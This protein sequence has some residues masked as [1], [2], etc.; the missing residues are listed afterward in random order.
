MKIQVSKAMAKELNKAIGFCDIS[1]IEMRPETYSWNVSVDS[2]LNEIDLKFDR[3]GRN[4]FKVLKIVYPPEFYA[5]PAYLTTRD[6]NRI[7]RESDRTWDGFINA[8]KS[9]VEI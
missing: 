8:V 9:A 3:E 7:Y 5:M 4:V 2:Y 6:L 1:Y